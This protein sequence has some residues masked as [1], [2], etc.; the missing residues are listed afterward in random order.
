VVFLSNR[1]CPN[2][3]ANQ[4]MRLNIRSNIHDILYEAYP[5]K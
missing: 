4:L 2:A 3:D 5:I 1:V